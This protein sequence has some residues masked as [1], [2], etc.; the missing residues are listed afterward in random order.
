[1]TRLDE[2][3]YP[4]VIGGI[5]QKEVATLVAERGHSRVVILCDKNVESIA[6]RIARAIKGNLGVVPFVLGERRKT[7]ATVGKVLDALARVG[8]DRGTLV[9]GVGG[10]VGGDLFGFAASIYMRD[11]SCPAP[12]P[13]YLIRALNSVRFRRKSRGGSHR[14]KAGVAAMPQP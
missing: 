11:G 13:E 7:L 2:L 9:I 6:R 4:V 3:G 1:M 8:A 5:V 14:G 10:G 12:V